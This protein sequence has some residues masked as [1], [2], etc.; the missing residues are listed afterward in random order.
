MTTRSSSARSLSL[1]KVRSSSRNSCG[2]PSP[3]ARGRAASGRGASCLRPHGS[4]VRDH[5][6]RAGALRRAGR[7]T[8]GAPRGC[9]C[10][11][12]SKCAWPLSRA[13]WMTSRRSSSVRSI[14]PRADH[15][16]A[17]LPYAAREVKPIVARDA[18]RRSSRANTRSASS[19]S[20]RSE[21][22]RPSS[23]AAIVAVSWRLSARAFAST[24]RKQRRALG[25]LLLAKQRARVGE[26]EIDR[27]PGIRR[28]RIAEPHPRA[29]RDLLRSA[30]SR[31]D[32][33]DE[34]EHGAVLD[35]RLDLELADRR[36]RSRDR[37]ASSRS[38]SASRMR[39]SR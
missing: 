9:G 27:E 5:A 28:R 32:A 17:R 18:R 23:S 10:A 30:R 19:S 29:R 6:G 14:S 2:T 34:V 16:H 8:A 33:L 21:S 1:S 25:E 36:S 11:T 4:G 31:R 35:Q 12:R 22:T 20:R 24:S 7:A 13:S 37:G 15:S 39:C 3:R 38:T 26:I